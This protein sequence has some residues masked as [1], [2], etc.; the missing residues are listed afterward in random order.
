MNKEKR[1]EQLEHIES[2]FECFS[3]DTKQ[4]IDELKKEINKPDEKDIVGC[5]R[6]PLGHLEEYLLIQDDSLIKK[7][8]W[9]SSELDS[10]DQRRLKN[11]NCYPLSMRQHLENAI[12]CI[13]AL[14]SDENVILGNECKKGLKYHYF[15]IDQNSINGDLS[16][17]GVYCDKIRAQYSFKEAYQINDFCSKYYDKLISMFLCGWL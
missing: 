14:M 7:G 3:K 9:T 8:H 13:E 17:Y 1:Q 2:E 10:V 16:I 11:G 12:E 15:R 6:K 5:Y 4:S